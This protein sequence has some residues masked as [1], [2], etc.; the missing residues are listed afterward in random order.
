MSLW[1]E[2]KETLSFLAA[3]LAD[4]KGRVIVDH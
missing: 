4:C 1:A 2:C 3:Q